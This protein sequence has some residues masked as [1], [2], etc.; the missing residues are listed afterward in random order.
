MAEKFYAIVIS[1]LAAIL[2]RWC[3]SLSPYSGKIWLERRIKS[4][5]FEE[6]PGP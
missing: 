1:A 5:L 2:V 3:V 6:K 4:N